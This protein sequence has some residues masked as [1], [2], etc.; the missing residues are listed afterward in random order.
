MLCLPALT[1]VANDAHAVGDSG[2]VVLGADER[3]VLG[4][5]IAGSPEDR[6]G[7]FMPL[8][9]LMAREGLQLWTEPA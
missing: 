1:P 9:A 2:G 7:L 8:G 3:T 6:L 5:H 4:M